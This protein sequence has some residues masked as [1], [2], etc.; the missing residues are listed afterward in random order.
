MEEVI[1]KQFENAPKREDDQKARMTLMIALIRPMLTFDFFS[2]R[3]LSLKLLL[4]L[5]D[6]K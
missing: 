3:K 5:V 2:H 1:K 6:F 4:K